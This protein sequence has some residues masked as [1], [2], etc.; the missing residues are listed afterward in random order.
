MQT[1]ELTMSMGG[2]RTPI[3]WLGNYLAFLASEAR[4]K[5]AR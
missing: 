5:L 3:N 4:R 2:L 1:V